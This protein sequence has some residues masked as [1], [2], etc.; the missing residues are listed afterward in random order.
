MIMITMM[1]IMLEIKIIKNI[2]KT[3]QIRSMWMIVLNNNNYNNNKWNTYNRKNTYRGNKKNKNTYLL[4]L[5]YEKTTLSNIQRKHH[6]IKTKK[7]MSSNYGTSTILLALKVLRFQHGILLWFHSHKSR[8]GH[9]ADNVRENVSDYG[10][11]LTEFILCKN[12][13]SCFYSYWL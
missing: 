6:F 7:G 5:N 12:Y 13:D 10:L 8:Y 1:K 4:H 3:K 9:S 11:G 2:K